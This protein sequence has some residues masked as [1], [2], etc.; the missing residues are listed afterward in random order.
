MTDDF[1]AF[2]EGD[3]DLFENGMPPTCWFALSTKAVAD[4][5]P[6]D[7]LAGGIGEITGTGYKRVG[8]R[9]PGWTASDKSIVMQFER[10]TWATFV[11]TDW[12]EAVR[13]VVLLT[14]ADNSGK[15][16]AAWNLRDGGLP[17]NM[18]DSFVILEFTPQLEIERQVP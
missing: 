1:L 13:S 12:P 7:T 8:Q 18:A 17:G 3:A 5:T 9:V 10:L 11:S 14:S 2:R 15:A 4:F 6:K 16:L